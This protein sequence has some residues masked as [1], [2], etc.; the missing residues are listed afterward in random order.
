MISG[1]A[2]C[3]CSMGLG[4]RGRGSHEWYSTVTLS[5]IM[6]VKICSQLIITFLS[7]FVH[8]ALDPMIISRIIYPLGSKIPCA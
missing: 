4:V 5:E 6:V 7:K 2:F 1:Y 8:I 3:D